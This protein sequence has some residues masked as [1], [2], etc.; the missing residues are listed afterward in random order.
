MP[1][2]YSSKS[3]NN[4]KN[5]VGIMNMKQIVNNRTK[6]LLLSLDIK[7]LNKKL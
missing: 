4:K 7:I 6:I 2:I 1:T 5:V 3:V